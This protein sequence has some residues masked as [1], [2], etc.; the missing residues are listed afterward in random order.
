[1]YIF[2]ST[3]TRTPLYVSSPAGDRKSPLPPAV[4][5]LGSIHFEGNVIPHAWFSQLKLPSGK[6]DLVGLIILAEIVYWYRPITVLDEKTGQQVIQRKKFKGDMFQSPLGYYEN[7]FGLTKDQVRKALRRL[8]TNGFIIR[9]YRDVVQH[10]VKLTGA[11]YVEPIP[12]KIL[13]ITYPDS[14][15]AT[16]QGAASVPQGAAS[17]PQ[18]AA[19]G[20]QGAASGPLYVDYY[21]TTTEIFETTTTTTTTPTAPTQGRKPSGDDRDGSS[22]S[23]DLLIFDF[24]LADFSSTEKARAAKILEGLDAEVAQQVL[25]VFNDAIGNCSIQKSRWAWL[26]GVT[27]KA[28]ANT[29]MPTSDLQARRNARAKAA[30]TAARAATHKPSP[31]WEA[32]RDQLRN[33][34]AARDYDTYIRPLQ[35]REDNDTLWL[36]APNRFVE[37]WVSAHLPLITRLLRPH[38]VL[39]I[40]VRLG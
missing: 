40:R 30:T 6:T 35:G 33:E 9:E 4:V 24:N 16:P 2:C 13:E 25:D 7:K 29:F 10:G 5:A 18:G 27:R 20:P 22:S 15:A 28:R 14:A 39:E 26:E 11:T 23:S 12:A 31:V 34:I 32:H 21:K 8:E 19:S 38:T 17:G 3:A 36:K 1:M 37:D